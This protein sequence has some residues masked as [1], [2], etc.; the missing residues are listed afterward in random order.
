MALHLPPA[1]NLNVDEARS[2][3]SDSTLPRQATTL[4]NWS[5]HS[6]AFYLAN[7]ESCTLVDFDLEE[8]PALGVALQI[9]MLLLAL[10]AFTFGPLLVNWSV[11]VD[12][13]IEAQATIVMS[14]ARNKAKNWFGV[15]LAHQPGTTELYVETVSEDGFAYHAG[16]LP[17]DIVSRGEQEAVTVFNQ[18]WLKNK[19][20]LLEV[21][22]FLAN[23]PP[24]SYPI[25]D[26]PLIDPTKPLKVTFD[27]EHVDVKN[28]EP[29]SAFGIVLIRNIVGSA[30]LMMFYIGSFDGSL[31]KL[32]TLGNIVIL[33][34]PALG[35][36]CADIFEVL[37]NSKTNAALYSVL[38]QS[39]LVGTALFMRILLGTR[40]STAQF[41]C[42]LVVTLVILCYMQV[43]DTVPIGK[44]WNGS[45]DAYDPDE[46][47]AESADPMGVLYAFAKIGLSIFMG[48]LGQRALQKEELQTLPLVGLQALMWSLAAVAV[49]PLMFLFMWSAN[50]DRG[51]FGGYPVEFRHCLKS[52][53]RATCSSHTAIVVEQGWDHRTVVVLLFYIFRELTLNG[54][55]RMFGALTSNLVN[56]SATVPTYFLSLA[57]LGKKFNFTKCGLIVCIFLQ[58][59]QYPFL[60]T[61]EETQYSSERSNG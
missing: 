30:I 5:T 51:I 44:Y 26:P 57:M 37:A 3:A 23:F 1:D 21:Q 13:P 55:R 31:G 52:W 41:T 9:L 27:M 29:Y 60:P 38:S 32:Y 20:Y 54:V 25:A 42:L 50:W 12:V 22:G 28:G 45:G 48:V 11:L 58:I 8:F 61:A 7:T 17:G 16:V 56:T 15:T 49:I 46:P 14:P 33:I 6:E 53:D 34:I 36:T 40:Q 39:R 43:P 35:W 2:A 18:S 47:K 4:S 10:C 59:V 24:K 19:D